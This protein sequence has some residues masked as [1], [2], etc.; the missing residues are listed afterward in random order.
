M[1]KN[2]TL[3]LLLCYSNL[4]YSASIAY[5]GAALC[6]YPHYH[7]IHVKSGQNWSN[8]FPDIIQRDLV[9]RLNRSYNALGPGKTIV[10]PEHLAT[11][12]LRDISP[13]PIHIQSIGE[14][15]II[16]DQDKLAWV[17]YDPDGYLIK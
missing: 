6:A 17:A 8:L 11:T 9:Q 1:K 15:Q 3:L 7:C 16:I 4:I 5:Y 12:T 13:F 10:V 14:K 2:F